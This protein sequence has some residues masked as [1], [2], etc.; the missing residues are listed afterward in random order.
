MYVS[1]ITTFIK[2]CMNVILYIAKAFIIQIDMLIRNYT[3]VISIEFQIMWKYDL[4]TIDITRNKN[5]LKTFL[6]RFLN[7]ST[8][9]NFSPEWVCMVSLEFCHI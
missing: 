4:Y 5:V 3:N 9:N 1:Y 6:W 8:F 2:R 7:I